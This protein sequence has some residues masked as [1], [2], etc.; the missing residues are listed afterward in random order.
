[1][2]NRRK[3]QKRNFPL[4]PSQCSLPTLVAIIMSAARFCK[5][6]QL[7]ISLMEWIRTERESGLWKMYE[8]SFGI[9]TSVQTAINVNEI[10]LLKILSI[11]YEIFSLSART[12]CIVI[13]LWHGNI[14]F[15]INIRRLFFAFLNIQHAP[16]TLSRMPECE[17]FKYFSL[18]F[19]QIWINNCLSDIQRNIICWKLKFHMIFGK[20]KCFHLNSILLWWVESSSFQVLRMLNF[21][22]SE[23][24]ICNNINEMQHYLSTL[25][26]ISTLENSDENTKLD[27]LP[28]MVHNVITIRKTS[29]R[30]LLTIFH[31]LLQNE[32]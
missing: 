5:I 10:Q 21:F 25:H 17:S 29:M 23:K 16:L 20:W 14:E 22:V 2:K 9:L 13:V 27:P 11:L 8:N 24:I 12:H 15:N 3:E 28:K 19:P 4:F 32:R 26:W 31:S 1:M 30:L 7:M 6:S 18:N